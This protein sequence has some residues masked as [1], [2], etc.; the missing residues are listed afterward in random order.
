MFLLAIF[1]LV[2]L[3]LELILES[4]QVQLPGG[5]VLHLLD[6]LVVRLASINVANSGILA[7]LPS[8]FCLIAHEGLAL[9]NQQLD[10]LGVV[11]G[12]V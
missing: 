10:C 7:G 1:P 11:D 12:E 4:G 5:R 2:L 3:L 8:V 6:Q 9:F